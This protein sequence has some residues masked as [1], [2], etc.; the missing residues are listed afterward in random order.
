[1]SN[2][3]D[4]ELLHKIH[5]SVLA[6]HEDLAKIGN[7]IVGNDDHHPA[8]APLQNGNWGVFC[9]GCSRDSNEFIPTCRMSGNGKPWPRRPELTETT[10]GLVR[11]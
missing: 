6:L 10:N 4:Y 9:F 2:E 3:T 5:A 8:I 7:D 11:A 1:M